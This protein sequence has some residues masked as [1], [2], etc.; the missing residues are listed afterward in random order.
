MLFSGSGAGRSGQAGGPAEPAAPNITSPRARPPV[1]RACW[2]VA[3]W[4]RGESPEILHPNDPGDVIFTMPM[5]YANAQLLYILTLDTPPAARDGKKDNVYEEGISWERGRGKGNGRPSLSSFPL[6]A[7]PCDPAAVAAGYIVSLRS[8]CSLEPYK[9]QDFGG[10]PDPGNYFPRFR[11]Y[12]FSSSR[13]K[14]RSCVKPYPL[15]PPKQGHI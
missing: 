6:S 10:V 4:S 14:R 13:Q 8:P 11:R 9:G 2:Y 12:P 5:G 7:L 1:C 15:L 3:V